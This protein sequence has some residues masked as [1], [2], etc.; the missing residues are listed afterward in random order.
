[1]T[2]GC[3]LQPKQLGTQDV[4]I[5]V[6]YLLHH[7]NICDHTLVTNQTT[8]TRQSVSMMKPYDAGVFPHLVNF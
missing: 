7:L 8:E 1:M 3:S 5:R 4:L 2:T 6:S